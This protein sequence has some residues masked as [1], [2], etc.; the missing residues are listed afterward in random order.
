MNTDLRAS[1]IER[2]QVIDALAG[3]TAAGRLSL[4]EFSERVDAVN[5]SRTSAELAV[6]TADLPGTEGHRRLA[7]R[8]ELIA[9]LVLVVLVLAVVVALLAAATGH[10]GPMG[11]MRHMMA[12]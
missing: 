5:R 10:P 6:L 12:P 11:P 9:A 7:V 3:H 4:D 2:Q 8:P 1:D